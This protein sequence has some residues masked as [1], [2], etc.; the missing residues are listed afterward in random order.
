MKREI[1]LA[2]EA[3][4]CRGVRRAVDLAEVALKE[5]TP[6]Y[7]LGPLIHNPSVISDLQK[8]GMKVL[9]PAPSIKD[10]EE[11]PKASRL[12]IRAHGVSKELRER[13]EK[14]S[15]NLIDGTC[16]HVIGIQ[17]KVAKAAAEGRQVIILGDKGHAEVLGLLGFTKEGV[18]LSTVE[19]AQNFISARPLTVVSQSTLD[20]ETFE[21]VTK[22]LRQRFPE[23]EIYD[24]RCD[25]TEKRQ[26]EAITLCAECEAM[27]VIGGLNSA[28][29]NR[30]AKLCF[31]SGKPTFFVTDL[32]NF[33]PAPLSKFS[34]IGL[35][36]GASTPQSDIERVLHALQTLP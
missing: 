9:A 1:K 11:L 6:I 14:S 4:F 10:L 28:N 18:A 2:K 33:D 17:R 25:A 24:T 35:T 31:Q 30:L 27:V 12:L 8:K 23:A 21:S 26:S 32:E 22:I 5:K 19:E 16:P 13:L 20:K 36:A 15:L 7:S 3:G 34:K 29:S